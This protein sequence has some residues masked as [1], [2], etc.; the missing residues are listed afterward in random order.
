MAQKTISQNPTIADTVL[1]SLDTPDANGCFLANPYQID[2]VTIYYIEVSFAGPNYGTL[3]N[4]TVDPTMQ[5][6][7]D[8]AKAAN[9]F[10]W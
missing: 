3:N 1:F 9:N 7:Y 2:S 6:Q 4:P 5:S 10:G 8:A